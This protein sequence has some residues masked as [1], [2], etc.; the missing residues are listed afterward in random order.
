MSADDSRT[1]PYD[2]G[3][4]QRTDE[5]DVPRWSGEPRAAGAFAD[6]PTAANPAAST[7][8]FPEAR[9][10]ARPSVPD[11]D[12]LG[13]SEYAYDRG[14]GARTS[15]PAPGL[16][17]PASS[18]MAASTPAPA[19]IVPHYA[20][21]P[22]GGLPGSDPGPGALARA[23]SLLLCLLL[24]GLAAALFVAGAVSAV[25]ESQAALLATDAAA[26]AAPVAAPILIG[27]A[28]LAA[29]LATLTAGWS[30]LGVTISGLILLVLGVATMLFPQLL[31][32]VIQGLI[33][34]GEV[35]TGI[36][37]IDDFLGTAVDDALGTVV[38]AVAGLLAA[39]SMLFGA[40]QLAAGFAAHA[41]RRA[42]WRRGAGR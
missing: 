31:A 28:I 35:S 2:F 41:A 20:P 14:A 5:F 8:E 12:G 19:P 38:A 23:G 37:T 40:V 4:G 39:G 24:S 34:T 7:A 32:G 13:A 16:A 9:P 36:G 22:A 10:A 25:V 29:F 11:Y 42:G 30:G 26:A 15:A 21:V 1:R 3:D 33:P 6:E 17:R 18:P 27:G